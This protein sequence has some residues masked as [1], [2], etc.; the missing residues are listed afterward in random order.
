[1]LRCNQDV[2][3]EWDPDDNENVGT[4]QRLRELHNE[5]Y[6]FYNDNDEDV[7][8]DTEDPAE[9]GYGTEEEDNEAANVVADVDTAA[10]PTETERRRERRHA[11]T[12]SKGERRRA[13]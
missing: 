12:S 7:S 5:T 9:D 2:G 1:M 11:C 13:A 6:S 4:S 8:G 3:R 10:Y